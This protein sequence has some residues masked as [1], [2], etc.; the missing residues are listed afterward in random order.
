MMQKRSTLSLLL[1][2][3]ML[4]FAL[5]VSAQQVTF[6]SKTVARCE[7]QVLNVT[8]DNASELGAVEVVFVIAG[9]GGS[10]FDAVN[11]NWDPGFTVLTNHI[12][13]LSGVDNVSP[14]TVR[15][16]AMLINA[17]D[18]CLPV[19]QTVIAQVSFTTNDNCAGTIELAGGTVSCPSFDISTQFANCGGTAVIPAVVNAG[20]VTV[21]NQN[22]TIAAIADDTIGWGTTHV[23]NAVGGDFDLPNGCEALSYSVVSGPAGL[24][25]NAISGTINWATTGADIGSH[26]VEIQV[27]DACGATASTT[28]SICVSNEA[29]VIACPADT[30]I[31][32]GSVL[33]TTVSASD[34]DGGPSPLLYTLLDNAGFVDATLNAATGE[35]TW[36]TLFDE[37]YKGAH[38]FTFVVTD[39]GNID[40]GCADNNADTCDFTVTVVNFLITIEKTHQSIQGQGQAVEVN[41]QNSGFENYPM[42]GFDF[43]FAYDASALTFQSATPGQFLTDCGWEY[44]TY[45]Y[46]SNGNCGTGCPSGEIRVNAIAET[47]NGSNHP[48]CF[49]NSGSIS[50]QLTVLNF[51]VTN[52]RTFECMYAPVQFYWYDCGDNTISDVSGEQLFINNHIYNFEDTLLINY[53]VDLANPTVPFPSYSG[54]TLDCDISLLDGKPDPLRFIDF[55]NGGVDIVCADSIDARG[56]LNLNE[57]ANEIAD[58]VLY[59]NYFIYGPSVFTVNLDGQIAASDVNA[60]GLTL[61]VADLVYLIRI[62]VGDALPYP[63]EVVNDPAYV[64]AQYQHNDAGIISV[65]KDVN[66]AAAHIIVAGEVEPTLL[67]NN[68]SMLSNFDGTNTRILV[69]SLENKNFTGD[70]VNVG[71]N[72]IVSLDMADFAGNQV[73]AKWIPS[74]YSVTQN[75]PNPFN[76]TTTV[77]FSLPAKA[78]VTMIIYNVN[79]QKVTEFSEAFEAGVHSFEWDASASASGV[80]FYRLTAGDFSAVKKMVLLK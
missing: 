52:D 36:P 43:L 32:L 65:S 63:K 50:N 19:G 57:I 45:R 80:Y 77:S 15:I 14:D 66:I 41:M 54:A 64:N 76:P 47:N 39:G 13:D 22:P 7:S 10:F 60:D 5:S 59:S 38:T 48:T 2:S 18:A 71:N 4:V 72:E 26:S 74:N 34:A 44:F 30:L 56:D 28:Y 79:G 42:G 21:Q 16:A 31:A 35:F 67:A 53:S 46:G 3:F 58:A 12:V 61:S 37:S 29:P 24:T 8:V 69:Y 33:T 55:V 20:T 51:L 40:P 1:I 25:V 11:V 78:D 75:Y 23:S 62:L 27:E 73:V 70:M 68:M 17:G 49:T 6:E 9:T